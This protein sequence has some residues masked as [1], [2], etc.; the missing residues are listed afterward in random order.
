MLQRCITVLQVFYT[1]KKRHEGRAINTHPFNSPFPGLPRSAGTRK[2]K[3]IW[4]LVK[5]E[6]VVVASAGTYASLH[7]APDRQPHQHP[8]TLFFTGGMSFLLPNQH[9]QSTE[10]TGC[11]INKS[12]LIIMMI[13][14]ILM[15]KILT[16]QIP[17]T[18]T[19][20]IIICNFRCQC[21]AS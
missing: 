10:G 12:I 4:I 5:Q 14:Y 20:V 21:S 17:L 15:I 7:L 2:V 9:R 13:N 6:T 16:E 1:A 3:T 19:A 11:A 18:C 8:T